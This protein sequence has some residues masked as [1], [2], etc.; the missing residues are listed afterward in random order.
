MARFGHLD[1]WHAARLVLAIDLNSFA[2]Y[3][4]WPQGFGSEVAGVTRW[5]GIGLGTCQ[6]DTR[7]ET[8][9]TGPSVELYIQI[10]FLQSQMFD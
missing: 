9:A 8:M 1:W 2:R 3:L 6:P 10:L 4:R 5:T 7:D